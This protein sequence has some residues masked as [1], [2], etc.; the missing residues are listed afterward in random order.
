VG[1]VDGIGNSD[2]VSTFKKVNEMKA[3]AELLEK[4]LTGFDLNVD[5]E[6][7]KFD[8]ELLED[9]PLEENTVVVN[10]HSQ[11]SKYH[12]RLLI[13]CYKEGLDIIK[14]TVLA[15]LNCKY[16]QNYLHVYLLDDGKDPKKKEWV[17]MMNLK[18]S[19]LH[20]ITR[21]DTFKG[22]GKA[23]NMNHALAQKIYPQC[24]YLPRDNPDDRQK[25]ADAIPENEIVGVLD[26]DMIC[27]PEFLNKLV[28][29]FQKDSH[30]MMVQSPQSFHNIPVQ[31]D[32]FDAHNIAFFQY[33][34]PAYASWNAATCCGTNFLVS[35]KALAKAGWFPYESVNEDFGLALR[36]HARVKETFHYHSEH[37]VFGE[38]P[39]DM[40]QIFQQRSRWAKGNLQIF[41]KENPLLNSDLNWVQ[42]FVFFNCGFCYF[43]SGV[44]NPIFLLIN[45]IAVWFDVFPVGPIDY[46]IC[47]IF[48]IYYV[49]MQFAM[50]FSP[51][52]DHFMTALWIQHKQSQYFTYLS[53]KA[54]LKV[55][56][57]I[58]GLG[59][60][61]TFKATEKNV[62]LQVNQNNQ[63]DLASKKSIRRDSS[64]GDIV[65][66]WVTCFFIILTVL[67]GI[68]D[69]TWGIFNPQY[70]DLGFSYE[71]ERDLQSFC[72]IKLIC[73]LWVAQ[74]LIGY[75]LPLFYAYQNPNPVSHAK[76]IRIL[77]FFDQTLFVMMFFLLGIMIAMNY[78][79]GLLMI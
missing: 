42:R 61:L 9:V 66:H 6:E 39:E 23:G 44:L 52:I 59:K 45:V 75:S 77:W 17:R 30:T 57:E 15:A 32:I 35:S 76:T 49:S 55:F 20:Y 41:F 51:N 60:A 7:C 73:L 2:W 37:L 31:S 14:Y 24:K 28:V 54:I 3:E 79:E 13:P 62:V 43:S 47:T 58:L 69:L 12:V 10:S 16:D 68:Y 33:M 56:R 46:K 70:F 48:L 27:T 19:N 21:T 34:M 50:Y 8:P 29:Y 26:A 71:S 11:T 25:A 74:F 36:L 67:Y 4:T 72:N 18:Y 38:A 1:Q 64:R 40:R 53:F 65:F 78:T 22:H 5:D 63:K